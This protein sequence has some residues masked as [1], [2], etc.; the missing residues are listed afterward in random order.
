MRHEEIR[1]RLHEYR[2]GESDGPAAAAVAAHLPGCAACRATLE[3]WERLASR[4]LKAA[5]RSEEAFVGRVMARIAEAQ[6]EPEPSWRAGSAWWLM[7]AFAA[8]AVLSLSWWPGPSAA[9]ED[10]LLAEDSSW[11]FEAQPSQADDVLTDGLG[12]RP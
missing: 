10:L 3:G 5:P 1:E 2:D 4:L 11:E 6:D 9:A 12:E 8:A 7:P